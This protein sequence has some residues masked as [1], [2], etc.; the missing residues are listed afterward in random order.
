MTQ[1]HGLGYHG[2]GYVDSAE[3]DGLKMLP[4]P[5][6]ERHHAGLQYVP[7]DPHYTTIE[8]REE[9]DGGHWL[10]ARMA[11]WY[12]LKKGT[13]WYE[14]GK[15]EAEQIK[16]YLNWE[17]KMHDERPTFAQV[18]PRKHLIELWQDLEAV[19]AP[20]RFRLN[21]GATE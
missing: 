2:L 9:M 21:E 17:R 1:Y 20:L 11:L 6:R 12:W 13:R 7:V 16:S 10:G 18:V 8:L 4:R 3:P 15:Q 5:L 19:E 14:K